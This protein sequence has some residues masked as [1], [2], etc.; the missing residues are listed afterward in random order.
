MRTIKRQKSDIITVKK[1]IRIA[2]TA[3]IE[4]LLLFSMPPASSSRHRSFVLATENG[5]DHLHANSTPKILNRIAEDAPGIDSFSMLTPCKLRTIPVPN[6]I[7]DRPALEAALAD[8]GLVFKSRHIDYF[9]EHLQRQNYPASLQEF[10]QQYKKILADHNLADTS[11][12]SDDDT[13]A[14]LGSKVSHRHSIQYHAHHHRIPSKLLDFLEA[15]GNGFVTCTSRVMET[16]TTNNGNLIKIVIVLHDGLLVE[17]AVMR[18]QE[19]GS[20]HCSVSVSC[21][22]GCDVGCLGALCPIEST[23]FKG[24]LSGGEILEQVVHAQQ[25]FSKQNPEVEPCHAVRKV[26]FMGSGEPLHNYAQVVSACK[27]LS[28]KR[29]WN[30]RHGR[31]TIGTVGIVEKIY[32]LT[33]DLPNVV[34]ALGLHA[35]TQELRRAIVPVAEENPLDELM[36]ALD[37]HMNLPSDRANGILTSPTTGSKRRMVI[38]EYIMSMWL[39]CCLP[40][41]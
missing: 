38:F 1:R 4:A 23:G 9:Y 17:T 32:T 26:S 29:V 28:N 27:A 33:Q 19:H 20:Y 30:L 24:N 40:S 25:V 13:V 11:I 34:I 15:P 39:L 37:N 6:S 16:T 22:V 3:K 31:I 21:Q 36:E 2:K 10:V 18:Y 12:S 5:D 8:A 14:S 41:F 35:P 7:M